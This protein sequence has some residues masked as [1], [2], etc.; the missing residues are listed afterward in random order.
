MQSNANISEEF[1]GKC[2]DTYLCGSYLNQGKYKLFINCS[3]LNEGNYKL[4]VSTVNITSE[5]PKKQFTSE[6][7][8]LEW[9]F[10]EKTVINSFY[11]ID[12]NGV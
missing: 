1:L 9:F 12:G 2:Q 3:N 5:Q 11:L 6:E 7:H 8:L 4:S 10:N